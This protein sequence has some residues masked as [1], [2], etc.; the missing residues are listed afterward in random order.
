MASSSSSSIS[1]FIVPFQLFYFCNFQ[2]SL[3]IQK[4]LNYV[5][6]NQNNGYIK[7]TSRLILYLKARCCY[8][9]FPFADVPLWYTIS[10]SPLSY[11]HFAQ[12]WRQI[13]EIDCKSVPQKKK[14]NYLF[15]THWFCC[16]CHCWC[17]KIHK[18]LLSL[19]G[20]SAT[21]LLVCFLSLKE[22]TYETRKNVF[23]FLSKAI[24]VLEIIKF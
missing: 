24:F 21:I 22:R 23:Y 6:H 4:L 16:L 19:K 17:T 11:F 15:H 10:G 1:H 3:N 18:N 13:W 5:F 9:L 8:F 12:I 7:L 14:K 20:V 2:I